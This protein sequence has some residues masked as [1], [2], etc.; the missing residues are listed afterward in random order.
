MK[1]ESETTVTSE[2]KF[3]ELERR[4]MVHLMRPLEA[5]ELVD[6]HASV[7]ALI[8][9]FPAFTAYQS[10]SLIK[11]N[12]G[13]AERWLIRRTTW[14]QVTDHQRASNPLKQD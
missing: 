4:A 6:I 10:W 3:R 5:R 14:E 11:S 2:T 13:K 12:A 8:W 7:I 9:R 1:S